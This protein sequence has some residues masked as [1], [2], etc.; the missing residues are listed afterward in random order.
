MV[1][2]DDRSIEQLREEI[3][4]KTTR[5]QSQFETISAAINQNRTHT[6]EVD[7]RVIE[8]V[9]ALEQ[10]KNEVKSKAEK[11]DITGLRRT[12]S[13]NGDCARMQA[14]QLEGRIT[15]VSKVATRADN[16]INGKTIPDKSRNRGLNRILLNIR[17]NWVMISTIVSFVVGII[18][19]L[20]GLNVHQYTSGVSENLTTAS[21]EAKRISLE[22]KRAE[23]KRVKLQL[24][25]AP[26]IAALAASGENVKNSI[27]KLGQ[28][29]KKAEEE[30][31]RFQ[32]D[33]APRIATLG[34][35]GENVKNSIDKLGQDLKK[36]EEERSKFQL[37]F[38][39]RMAT[40]ETRDKEKLL[41]VD[42]LTKQIEVIQDLI[43]E[44]KTQLPSLSIPEKPIKNNRKSN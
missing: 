39:L 16:I 35:A 44:L 8:T 6:A 2:Q 3:A 19:F 26:R 34:N 10:V 43:K 20:V 11:A 30:R 22:L 5:D 29:L 21:A 13:E 18:T 42:E 24:D 1:S 31:G 23:E 36:A 9:R 28:D 4:A 40:Q 17:N 37:D 15:E 14:K 27:D 41:R 25:I 33:I 12:L 38:G 7:G 32:L